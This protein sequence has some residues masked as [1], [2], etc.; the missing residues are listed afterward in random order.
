LC[1]HYIDQGVAGVFFGPQEFG[2][3]HHDVNGR[4]LRA[5]DKANIPVVLLDRCVLRYPE[6]SN[7]DLIGLDNRRAGF[8]MTDHLIRQGARHVAFLAR[9]GSAETVEDRI[10]GFHQALYTHNLPILKQ[11]VLRGDAAD[12]SFVERTLLETKIDAILCANDRTAASLMQT[13][14]SLGARIPEEFRIA[15]ID[16][17]RYASLLPIPLTTFQQP[18]A[19][20]GEVSMSAMLERVRNRQLPTRS[21][22]LNGSLVIRQS[23]GANLSERMS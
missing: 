13:L 12:K 20:I 15:G 5:L 3:P 4:I 22:L 16:D 14:L 21:I 2:P 8:I 6:R 11:M 1:R 18:C 9:Q 10:A 23:C 19:E 7:Y 17:V